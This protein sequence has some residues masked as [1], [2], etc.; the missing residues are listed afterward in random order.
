MAN[1][2]DKGLATWIEPT[3]EA[4]DSLADLMSAADH[5]IVPVSL[6]MGVDCEA[7]W[8]WDPADG[9]LQDFRLNFLL[10]KWRALRRERLMPP[11]G[12]IDPL[13]LAPALGFVI[14]IDV[15]PEAYDCRYRLYGAG[16]S[17]YAGRDWTGF[18]TSE[19]NRITRTHVSLFYRAGYR[20]IYLRPTPLFTWHRLAS[21]Y[22][23]SSWSRL[24]LPLSG[25]DGSVARFLV[26]N[27]PG[28]LR[29]LSY[30]EEEALHRRLRP[31]KNK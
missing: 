17:K 26:G 30:E 7:T 5:G 1:K 6:T 19:M 2:S 3:P 24:L 14:L 25:D 20:A 13:E 4:I 16:I 27:I 31:E 22:S 9:S 12:A 10:Q 15:L 29:Y 11:M 8:Q 23:A 21:G 18:L 28:D